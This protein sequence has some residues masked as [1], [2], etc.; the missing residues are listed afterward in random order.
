MLLTLALGAELAILALLPGKAAFA[1]HVVA[2][3][4]SRAT[5]DSD[6][7]T[8]KGVDNPT[9]HFETLDLDRPPTKVPQDNRSF[10]RRPRPNPWRYWSRRANVQ[11]E[12]RD[13][14]AG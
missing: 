11:G 13:A 8:G 9:G 6:R 5:V 4:A 10:P 7:I 12:G 3:K 14:Q 2:A 1:S